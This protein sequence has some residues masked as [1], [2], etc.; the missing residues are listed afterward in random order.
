[1]VFPRVRELKPITFDYLARRIRASPGHFGL[2]LGAGCSRSS[3]VL[4]ASEIV[5]DIRTTWNL[6]D[7]WQGDYVHAMRQLGKKVEQLNYLQ[8]LIAG[9]TPSVLHSELAELV[10][11]RL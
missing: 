7:Q 1:M 3:G 4:T 10:A 6:G 11:A 9:R 2:L 5:E 8:N